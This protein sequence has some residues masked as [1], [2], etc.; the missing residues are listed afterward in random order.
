MSFMAIKELDLDL[1]QVVWVAHGIV[2]L[3][4]MGLAGAFLYLN[5]QIPGTSP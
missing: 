2:F 1:A 3:V 5:P 4:A